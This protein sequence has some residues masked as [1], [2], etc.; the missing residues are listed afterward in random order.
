MS[1][2]S[3]AVVDVVEVTKTIWSA[4]DKD[5]SEVPES[6]RTGLLSADLIRCCCM[7]W[8]YRYY[9]FWTG[10]GLA[11]SLQTILAI[12][13]LCIAHHLLKMF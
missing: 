11:S 9:I 7:E 2:L 13:G 6:L 4:F 1:F 8:T 12:F 10:I 5:C 3:V